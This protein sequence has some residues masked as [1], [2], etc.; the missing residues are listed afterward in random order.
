MIK[1][2]ALETFLEGNKN[3]RSA[4]GLTTKNPVVTV[5]PIGKYI[6]SNPE[7]LTSIKELMKQ[8][9]DL[10]M[11]AGT[12][13]GKTHAI[14]TVFSQLKDE[15]CLLATPN[16]VQNLQNEKDSKNKEYK[17]K[18]VVGGDVVDIFNLN[19]QNSYSFVYD[20]ANA[21]DKVFTTGR[22]VNLIIDEAHQ[23]T[24]A[25]GYRNPAVKALMVLA[26]RVKAN[27]G[28]VIY[29]TAT[30]GPLMHMQFDHIL[31]FLPEDSSAPADK[32]TI[33]KVQGHSIDRR[34]SGILY[35]SRSISI[36]VSRFSSPVDHCNSLSD[37]FRI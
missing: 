37:I 32:V 1:K 13:R 2:N 25:Y 14:C 5:M 19:K 33:Y 30:P 22:K 24:E 15:H 4:L 21:F 3:V 26:E 35:F 9:G 17:I 20:K 16:K 6:S 12:G 36:P 28:S 10:L 34:I 29:M 8:A 7:N 11:L 31:Q 23:M 27:G 18:S